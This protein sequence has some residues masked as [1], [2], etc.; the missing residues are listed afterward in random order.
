VK[1]ILFINPKFVVRHPP[2]G[3]GYLASYIKKYYPNRY[4]FRLIDYSFQ[5]DNDLFACLNEY[6]P[7]IIAITS[8]TNTFVDAIRIATLVKQHH[9]IPTIIGGVHITAVPED[10]ID[11]PFDIAVLGEGEQTFL[12]LLINFDNTGRL[13]DE[14]I[15]GIAF[16]KDNNIVRTAKRPLIADLDTIP[17]PDYSLFA[18]KEFYTR[19]KAMAHGFYAKGASMIPSRG[20][21]YSD[22]SFC[23]SDIVWSNKVR[24]FSPKRVFEEIA[25]LVRTYGL[26]S[27]IFLDDNFTTSKKWLQ[28][29]A[30]YITQSEFYNY[31]KFDCESIAEFIDAEKLDILKSMGCERIE[32][33]FESGCQRIVN[34]LK[35]KR[36]SVQKNSTAIKLCNQHGIKVLG[37][38][39]FGWFD[40]T[41]EE[42]LETIEFINDHHIDFV[43]WHTLAP[44]PGT[45]VWSEF[46]RLYLEE[47]GQ[48]ADHS[49]YRI[50][51]GTGMFSL[52]HHVDAETAAKI[53]HTVSRHA[54][55]SSTYIVH[56][57]NLSQSDK[58]ELVNSM[59]VDFNNSSIN[60]PKISISGLNAGIFHKKLSDLC[61]SFEEFLPIT[62]QH[63]LEDFELLAGHPWEEHAVSPTTDYYACLHALAKSVAPHKVL[64]VG[65]AFGMS[66]AAL[67][68]ACNPLE[69]F[70][71]IDLGFFH[72]EY[73]FPESNLRFAERK[74]K[75]WCRRHGI[76]P[77]KAQYFQANSQPDGKSD[78]DN[79]IQGV[80]HWAEVTDLVALLQP[81]SFDVIF[82][83][84][85]H[86]EDGLY[87]D[88]ASFW[89]YLRPGGLLLCDDLHDPAI[90][91]I[92]FSWAGDTLDSFHRFT[93]EHSHEIDEYYIWNFPHVFPGSL[94]GLRPFGIIRKNTNSTCDITNENEEG[95]FGNVSYFKD[96]IRSISEAD[97]RLYYRDQ[98][99]GSLMALV[100]AVNRFKPT[101]VVELG[102]LSG[103]SLRAWLS[104]DPSLNVTAID[105]SF[106]TLIRSQ[107]WIALDLSRV[108]LLQ[109]NILTID[110]ATLWSK[111]DRVIFYVDAHDDNGVPIMD[112]VLRNVLPALPEGSVVMVDDV[113]HSPVE[114]NETNVRAFFESVMLEEIDPLQCFDGYYASYWKGGS[115]FGFLE[116]IPLLEWVN[117]NRIELEFQ[118]GIKSIVFPWGGA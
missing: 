53:Y 7:D 45:K 4:E 54:D 25:F 86:T 43:A 32:F 110:F 93:R 95:C 84:G 47:F 50:D 104:A 46:K 89:Q 85:K 30:A 22:C 83:D 102:T 28:E 112:Y 109:Q 11:T 74:I 33:G 113:W 8:T 31:F 66:G 18:M 108:T 51:T 26:N 96:M 82:V 49:F 62:T 76:S 52:N 40:E 41:C 116:V 58:E 64:E 80:P 97:N 118:P 34:A 78:N 37:N 61:K 115:F 42:I 17:M 56:N 114:L 92:M 77:D 111:E 38:F 1:K 59:V 13:A 68:A 27:I 103:M 48:F 9:M 16:V 107:Q 90:Y 106:E 6:C 39:I 101:R 71:S 60:N 23:A 63:I 14:S 70:I 73:N 24:M 79:K 2:L 12:E 44:Y 99:V 36:A 81:E 72:K 55:V 88:M 75:G 91:K 100:D 87:N 15:A 21:P 35:N 67:V 5:T 20:C 65:T 3:L 57:I 10:I 105:L 94:V 29:L 19:P 98:T 117:H 69:L